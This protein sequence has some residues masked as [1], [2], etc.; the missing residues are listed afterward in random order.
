MAE[1]LLKEQ[2]RQFRVIELIASENFASSYTLKLQGSCLTNKYSEGY[3][4]ARYYGGNEVIDEIEML[5]QKR[6]LE[7]YK[8]DP[9]E[10][11]C[12][13]QAFS[14]CPANFAIYT[15]LIPPGERLMGMSLSEGGHLSHGFYTPTRKVSATSLFWESK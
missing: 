11:G 15:A 13:V 2:K 6:T 3:P 8:L 4:G 14:G 12:N 7:A 9:N 5:A 1:L 10:W